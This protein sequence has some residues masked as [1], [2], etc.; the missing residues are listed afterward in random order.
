ML[1]PLLLGLALP[2]LGEPLNHPKL[3]GAIISAYV[4]DLEGNVLF[5]KNSGLHMVPASN[6]KLL[7]CAFALY[8]LGPEFRPVTKFWKTREGVVVD[9]PGDPMLTHR[10]LV[11]MREKLGLDR[12]AR[13]YVRQE[14][15]PVIPP[16]WEHDD[17]P[18]RY[19]APITAFTVNRGG[20]ELWS[21]NGRPQLVPESYGVRVLYT[22]GPEKPEVVY[23][24]FTRLVSVRGKMPEKDSRL[25]TL[26]VPRP[27]A[28]AASLLG[29]EINDV[30]TVPTV[31]P[32]GT[33]VGSTTAEMIAACLPSSDNNLAEHLLLL[34]ARKQGDLG[35]VPYTTAQSRM[36]NFLTRVAGLKNG[37][38]KVY[39]GSGMSRHN[40]VTTR[41]I[42]QLL[43]WADKQPTAAL[44]RASLAASGKGTLATRLQ[45]VSFQGKTGT[46]DM[47][48]ALSGYV[49][50]K[51]GKNLV[52]SAVLNQFGCTSL[53]ARNL[54]D[55]F[56]KQVAESDLVARERANGNR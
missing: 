5:E 2:Q 43:N 18:N 33:I 53:E 11:E 41:G 39:D 3:E 56:V 37:D 44:W 9:A 27:D 29:N 6:Q 34:G 10:Q 28:A 24:P 14:Y 48:V 17:L 51:S 20:F 55:A 54:V 35:R 26:A 38:V 46:L 13:V 23:D 49:T 25:D 19:A 12:R 40:F 16:T 32:D 7:T 15:A 31:A 36:T 30:P 22:P 50:Q 52:I 8:S 42:G 21:K 4:A 1:A 47:V 45:G